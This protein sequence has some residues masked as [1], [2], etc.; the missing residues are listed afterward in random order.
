MKTEEMKR[1]LSDIYN[2]LAGN[3]SEQ[4]QFALTIRDLEH[5]HVTDRIIVHV[6]ALQIASAALA[7]CYTLPNDPEVTLARS[8][9]SV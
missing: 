7:A 3:H 9:A 4:A 2:S 8:L 1:R 5:S 6:M